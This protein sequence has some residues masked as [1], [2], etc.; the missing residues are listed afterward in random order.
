MACLLDL[1]LPS[2][3][4]RRPMKDRLTGV[5]RRSWVSTDGR[6]RLEEHQYTDGHMI[7]I[8]LCRQFTGLQGCWNNLGWARS[9]REAEAILIK[10]LARLQQAE[11]DYRRSQN[12]R[13]QSA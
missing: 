1:P 12:L 2:L 10:H 8:P 3:N 5:R 11:H 9:R 7:F 13:R 4:W 6:V